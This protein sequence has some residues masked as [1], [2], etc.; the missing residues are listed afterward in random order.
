MILMEKT[1]YSES[2]FKNQSKD[3]GRKNIGIGIWFQIVVGKH[4]SNWFL[5]PDPGFNIYLK[6]TSRLNQIHE[7]HLILVKDLNSNVGGISSSYSARCPQLWWGWS[8]AEDQFCPRA[9]WRWAIRTMTDAMMGKLMTRSGV[10]FWL[11]SQHLRVKQFTRVTGDPRNNRP[12][13]RSG[14]HQKY[15]LKKTGNLV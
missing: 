8:T 4:F 14:R 1:L 7:F 13:P 10:G 3:S 15:T 11:F 2:G 5:S 12:A 6:V 9:P